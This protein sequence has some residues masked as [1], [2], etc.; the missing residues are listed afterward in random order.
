MTC[1][2]QELIHASIGLSQNYFIRLRLCSL[3]QQ[4]LTPALV[5]HVLTNLYAVSPSGAQPIGKPSI[6]RIQEVTCGALALDQADLTSAKRGRQVVYARQ[7]AMYLSKQ[8]TPRSLPEIGRRFGGR[9]HTTVIHAVRQIEKLRAS[10][11]ELDADS[12]LLTWQL[13][14]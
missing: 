14:G 2:S 13:E 6:D 10:D 1:N 5:E 7:V 3:T 9:D 8:L 11:A 4:P 12:R